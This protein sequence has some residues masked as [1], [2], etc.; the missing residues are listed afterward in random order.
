MG[1]LL[2]RDKIIMLLLLGVLLVVIVVPTGRKTKKTETQTSVENELE[3]KL[4]K[5]LSQTTLAGKSKVL[6]TMK[7]DKDGSLDV[8]KDENYSA[9]K[10]MG[11]LILC[12]KANDMRV[13]TELTETVSALLG[14]PVNRIKVLKMEV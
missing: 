7:N 12:E 11:V 10:I 2:K 8:V 5:L 4:S 13:V 3:T 9:A 1:K 6:I 14:V